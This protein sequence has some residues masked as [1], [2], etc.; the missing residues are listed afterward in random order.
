M[1]G[2][3]T[4]QKFDPAAHLHKHGWKGKG[5][6]L[7]HGHATRPLAIV[8]KKTLSGVGKD[9]DEA[10]P[11]WDHIFASTAASLSLPNSGT[12]TPIT[13]P[14]SSK[15]QMVKNT[16]WQTHTTSTLPISVLTGREVARRGLY[17]RFLRG[18]VLSEEF[19]DLEEGSSEQIG[20][21]GPSASIGIK[22]MGQEREPARDE[23]KESERGKK[24]EIKAGE[25][26]KEKKKM[27]REAK[28]KRKAE[29]AAKAL[30][31]SAVEVPVKE[32]SIKSSSKM[33]KREA[34]VEKAVEV[35]EGREKINVSKKKRRKGDGDAELEGHKKG[36]KR[37]S[38]IEK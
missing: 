2:T 4:K 30:L 25:E 28:A 10:V 16:S 29:K 31:A 8:Q 36:K 11:F 15:T 13:I 14:S 37:K 6:A 1:V 19:E 26:S 35:S 9:R 18:A 7:K 33:K 20:A 23:G 27:R 24:K 17:S 3:T 21:A 32:S 34:K 22:N 38:V 12:S 5:T